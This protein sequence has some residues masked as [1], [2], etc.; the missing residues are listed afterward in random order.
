MISYVRGMIKVLD[1]PRLESLSC[2]CYRVVKKETDLLLHYLPQR[3]VIRD[4]EEIPTVTLQQGD[5]PQVRHP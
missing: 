2:E 5:P 1:R 3:Q 4:V